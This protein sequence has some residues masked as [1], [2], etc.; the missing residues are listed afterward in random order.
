MR[1]LLL[2]TLLCLPKPAAAE[3]LDLDWHP[4]VESAAEPLDAEKQKSL[5]TR[6]WRSRFDGIGLTIL[7]GVALGGAVAATVQAALAR[8]EGDKPGETSA[9]G[10]AAGLWAV[11]GVASVAGPITTSIGHNRLKEFGCKDVEFPKRQF[12]AQK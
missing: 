11:G 1:F 8:S 9:G 3:P 7:G 12:E 2:L 6:A 4:Q 10:L 5:C